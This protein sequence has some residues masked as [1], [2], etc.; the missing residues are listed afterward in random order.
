MCMLWG[1]WCCG[2]VGIDLARDLV[3]HRFACHPFSGALITLPIG[4]GAALQ[5]RSHARGYADPMVSDDSRNAGFA[6]LRC[7]VDV[8]D[9]IHRC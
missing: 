8:F 3:G 7:H 5:K 2:G 6:R 4:G 1:S 9:I